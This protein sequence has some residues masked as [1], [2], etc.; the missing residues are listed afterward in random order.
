MSE[1]VR[2]GQC[3]LNEAEPELGLGI[4]VACDYRTATLLFAAAAERRCYAMQSAPLYR[5]RIN[6]GEWVGD[7]TG[8]GF[9]V[10]SVEEQSGLL[11]YI[12]RDEAGDLHSL[13]EA[14]LDPGLPLH[15]PLERLLGGRVDSTFWFDL[16][17]DTLIQQRRLYAS[18]LAGLL[19]ARVALL[20]HQLSVVA[21][22]GRRLVPRILLA[23]EVGLGK[24][25]EAGMILHQ[26]LLAGLSRRVLIVVPEALSYPWWYEMVRRFNLHF[27]L[28]DHSR[29]TAIESEY[30]EC[31]PFEQEQLV[32]IDYSLLLDEARSRQLLE[33]QWDLLVVD[34][35]HHMVAGTGEGGQL[36]QSIARLCA[37]IESVLLLTATPEQLGIEEHF[38]RLAL[39]DPLRFDNLQACVE[40][41]K[42]YGRIAAAVDALQ[43]GRSLDSD[44]LDLLGST[45]IEG[46]QHQLIEQL[47]AVGGAVDSETAQ[48]ARS[49]LVD[50]LIDR[51]GTSRLMFRNRRAVIGGLPE[52]RLYPVVLPPPPAY[53]ECG[54]ERHV[55]PEYAWLESVGDEGGSGWC[56]FDPRVEW[57]AEWL[58]DHRGEPAVLICQHDESAGQLAEWLLRRHAIQAATFTAGM[59]LLE[60]DRAAAYFSD[61]EGG[62]P[63]LISSAIGS[64]G[65]N[66]QHGHHLILFDLPPNP[67]R[68]EQTIGRVD[69]IGQRHG[70]SIYLPCLQGGAQEWLYRCYHHGLDSFESIDSVAGEVWGRF[71]PE[72]AAVLNGDVTQQQVE[73]LVHK[74]QQLRRQLDQEISGG[75]DRLLDLHSSRL[76]AGESLAALIEA[77]EQDESFS[78]WFERLL[79]GCGVEIE[80][81]QSSQLLWLHAAED[82]PAG[83]LQLID[84]EDGLVVT[85]SRATAL[86]N[87]QAQWLTREHPLVVR[88]MEMVLSTGR[89]A[90][91]AV[92]VS[93]VRLPATVAAPPPGTLLLELVYSLDGAGGVGSQVDRYLPLEP[94]T[95][96]IDEKMELWQ[97]R[98]PPAAIAVEAN[99]IEP[100]IVKRVIDARLSRIRAMHAEGTRIASEWAMRQLRQAAVAIGHELD[101]ERS[102]LVALQ[103]INHA[104]R[105]DEIAAVDL[106]R[107]RLLHRVTSAAARLDAV[108]LV[109][110]TR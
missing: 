89:G 18:P 84:H 33:A 69:R 51:H 78:L 60:R 96:L 30:G 57:L 56:R 62:C 94:L 31:N 66:F 99:P 74:L 87:E 5:V 101:E 76:E 29:C 91:G 103:R 77:E 67:D 105:A 52:R 6:P 35:A 14:A 81:R 102:R 72:V 10:E 46:D 47:Q 26:R 82:Q 86:L 34:E 12:G 71:A 17:R 75:R 53:R 11:S 100:V 55:T 23:D 24:T 38:R 70:I 108:R 63:L 32:L 45:L 58:R 92:Q 79:D 16:R 98:L 106:L 90:S 42:G 109:V 2:V 1:K 20:P 64:E 107:Q 50:H 83:A 41:R 95:L 40:E 21:Q 49:A 54:V 25:I 9:R 104:V 73:E 8:R 110:V 65:R 36:Y 27:H 37:A 43:S 88:A 15:R 22:V 39:L 68:L 97:E 44:T 93:H 4:V 85:R 13:P 59:S 28:F 19:G 3:W 7:G 80:S 48:R 61:P